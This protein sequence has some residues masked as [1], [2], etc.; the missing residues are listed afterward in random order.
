MSA[1]TVTNKLN[2]WKIK[3]CHSVQPTDDVMTQRLHDFDKTPLLHFNRGYVQPSYLDSG[4]ISAINLFETNLKAIGGRFSHVVEMMMMMMMS[5][6]C[7]MVGRR[8]AFSLISSRGHCQRSSPSR[9][10]DTPRVEFK[11]AQNLS[12]GLNE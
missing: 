10:T 6:F 4:R 11:T 1:R 7:G 2:S 8:K 5:C 9:I 3:R 12:S